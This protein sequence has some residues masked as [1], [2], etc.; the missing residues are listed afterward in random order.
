MA[1]I[2][3]SG[4]DRGRWDR[5]QPA[6]RIADEH[7]DGIRAR[8]AVD[9]GE[10]YLTEHDHSA[11]RPADYSRTISILASSD[12][13]EFPEDFRL[14]TIHARLHGLRELPQ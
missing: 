14:R 9:G 1:Q 2:E 10:S 7:G 13:G 8:M 11:Y 3:A 4:A 12:Y 6:E 5:S